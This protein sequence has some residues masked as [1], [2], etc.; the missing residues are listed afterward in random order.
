M[1]DVRGPVTLSLLA[2]RLGQAQQGID[3]IQKDLK[4]VNEQALDR[5]VSKL[6]DTVRWLTRTVAAALIS[7]IGAVVVALAMN[8]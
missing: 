3:Q 2:E 1:P 4:T 8:R 7:G 5:R 6:E